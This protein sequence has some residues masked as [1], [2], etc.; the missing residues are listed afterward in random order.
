MLPVLTIVQI[1]G[2][3]FRENVLDFIETNKTI[4]CAGVGIKRVSSTLMFVSLF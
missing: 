4:H 3:N 2:V 1:K